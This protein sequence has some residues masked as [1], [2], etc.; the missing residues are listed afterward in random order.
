[1][2]AEVVDCR[3][4]LGTEDG[5]SLQSAESIQTTAAEEEISCVPP[6]HQVLSHL[7]KGEPAEL[8]QRKSRVMSA[9]LLGILG[10]GCL[11]LPLAT[12][13]SLL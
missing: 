10:R 5:G 13:D 7:V 9:L 4:T 6:G 3:Q 12:K 2:G 1:M 8:F 11:L